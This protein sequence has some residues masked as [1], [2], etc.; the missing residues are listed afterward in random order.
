MEESGLFWKNSPSKGLASK[1]RLGVK[2]R[3]SGV[4]KLYSLRS[5]SSGSLATTRNLKNVNLQT[6]SCAYKANQKAGPLMKDWLAAFYQSIPSTRTILLDNV[7]THVTS[8]NLCPHTNSIPTSKLYQYL[9]ATR[10][11]HHP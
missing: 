8:I 7:S 11:R 4:N 9:P 6:L 3:V 1:P 2:N 10:S 5:F